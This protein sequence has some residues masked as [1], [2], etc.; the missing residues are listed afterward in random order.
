VQP[1]PKPIAPIVRFWRHVR[2]DPSPGACWEWTGGLRGRGYGMFTPAHDWKVPAHRWLWEYLH[3][4][5]G[6]LCALHKCDNPRCIRPSHVR[7]GT[8]QDNTRDMMAKGRHR[9]PYL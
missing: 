9:S 7:V 5:L 4:P 3:G 6:T 2:V 8:K 1:G